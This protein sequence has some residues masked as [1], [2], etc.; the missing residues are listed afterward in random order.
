MD[1]NKFDS[2]NETV[3]MGGNEMTFLQW[4][5]LIETILCLVSGVLLAITALI[6][7]TIPQ[8]QDIEGKCTFHLII[9]QCF[10]YLLCF[11]Q[12]I[13]QKN[14]LALVDGFCIL[15]CKYDFG[16]TNS[17]SVLMISLPSYF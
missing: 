16:E 6:Y 10:F 5:L 3:T 7:F 12:R 9:T 17:L 14:E 13:A 11:F 1:P 2:L 15:H 8:T 4:R